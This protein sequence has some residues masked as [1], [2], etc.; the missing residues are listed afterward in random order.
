MFTHVIGVRDFE[1]VA[2]SYMSHRYREGTLH[3]AFEG[4]WFWVIPFDNWQG[5]TNPLVS[6]GLTLDCRTYPLDPSTRVEDEFE[7]FLERVP[8]V[9]RQLADAQAVRPWTRT[10]RIQYS[11]TRAAGARF[12]LLSHA[13]GFIDPLY[14]RGLISTVESIDAICEALLPALDDDDFSDERFEPVDVVEQRA[15]SFTDRLVSASYA[16][17]DDFELWNLWVRVWGIGVHVVESHLGS[18]LAMGEASTVQRVEDPILSEFEEKNYRKYF[19]ASFD[20]MSRY[21]H[22]E[23][24]VDEA[25]TE[26][27]RILEGYEFQ[28]PLRDRREGQ[29]WAMKHPMVRDLFLGVEEQHARWMKEA[30]DPA[31]MEPEA[32]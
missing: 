18:V 22:D 31:L 6:L 11:S 32:V 30:P 25:R 10:G 19:E 27:A 1:D 12:A 24:T 14:S 15:L 4:G 13:A 23:L 17:W 21:S 8:S 16:S 3:H 20:V 5:S 28:M 2:T 26:L 9:A 29:E 7:S